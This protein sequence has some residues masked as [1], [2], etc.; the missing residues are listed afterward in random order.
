MTEIV[1]Q[2]H[3]HAVGQANNVERVSANHRSHIL[4]GV[5]AVQFGDRAIGADQFA[6]GFHWWGS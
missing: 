2:H 6:D 4:N 3:V 5:R 1:N